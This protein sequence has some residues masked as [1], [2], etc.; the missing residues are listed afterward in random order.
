MERFK[1]DATRSIWEGRPNKA[2][3]K[4][5]PVN[6]HQKIALRLD[7]VL[8]QTTMAGFAMLPSGAQ[9]KKLHGKRRGT[10]QIRAGG[11]YRVRFKWLK[12]VGAIE[13]EV[14]DFHDGDKS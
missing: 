7:F 14:K 4:I 13:I 9:F 11:P 6:L 3:R 12:G 1:D 5:V 8:Q 10:Y 2:A